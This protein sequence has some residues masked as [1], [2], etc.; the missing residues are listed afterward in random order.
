MNPDPDRLAELC[1][2]SP[3]RTA[4]EAATYLRLADPDDTGDAVAKALNRLNCLVRD[5]RLKPIRGTRP[6][7]YF[8]AELDRYVADETA[9]FVDG[10]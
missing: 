2:A 4:V 10:E 6:R 5:G 7:L 3:V 8:A 9:A 1:R